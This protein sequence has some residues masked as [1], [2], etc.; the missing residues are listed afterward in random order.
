MKHTH[1]KPQR[2]CV[3]ASS[4]L[5]AHIYWIWQVLWKK[6]GFKNYIYE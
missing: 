6:K 5:S 3:S 1:T 4:E 2:V